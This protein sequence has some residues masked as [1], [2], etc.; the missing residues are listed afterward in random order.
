MQFSQAIQGISFCCTPRTVAAYS[1]LATVAVRPGHLQAFFRAAKAA[2][3]L[4]DFDKALAICQEGRQGAPDMPEWGKL[5]QASRALPNP[6]E[7]SGFSLSRTMQTLAFDRDLQAAE[8]LIFEL[9]H[10]L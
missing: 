3:I 4:G 7:G 5:E 2:L 9:H 8:K 6:D 1:P 10:E